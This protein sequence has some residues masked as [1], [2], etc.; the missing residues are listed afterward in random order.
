MT[1]S[2]PDLPIDH[3]TPA[4]KVVLSYGLGEDST[5]I[6][7]RWIEDP[8]SR[9]FDLSD[10]VVITAMTGDE[11]DS[12]RAAVEE[13]VLPRMTAAGI[14]Y[15]QVGRGRRHVT[16][17]GD[18]V[19]ILDDSSSPSRLYIEGE[20]SLYRE[21]TEA[22]TVPQSGGA[23]LC[24]VH[25]KGDALDPVI[26][27]ITRG[28]SYRHVM[29]FEAGEQR[30][31]VKDAMFNTD[32][33]T[34]EY[35]LI[36][37]GWTRDDAIAYTRSVTG[38]SVGKSACTFCPFT[39]ANKQGRADVFARYAADPTVG[40]KTLLME[41]LSLALNPAQGL[42]GGRR[43]IDMLRDQKLDGVV[44]AFTAVLEDQEHA[45][46]DV[47]RIPRPRKTDPTKLGNAARS[48]RVRGR[49]TRQGMQGILDRLAADGKA[50]GLVRPV[51]GEDGILRVYQHERGPAFPAIER[52]FV[53]APALAAAKE[54][55]KFDQWWS[56]AVATIA[57]EPAAA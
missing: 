53:V 48:I 56:D 30:R 1:I 25:A 55:E 14:R 4:P 13:H 17:A 57:L 9:D 29:G 27:R 10:L 34:G 8:T 31:A 50:K 21:M 49:G 26:A 45:I 51:V 20:Y 32:L 12:T 52:Y 3:S 43:L 42:V 24:S 39:F 35:P 37:W 22:G 46:Y 44:D 19:T 38:T 33:R 54:H 11:W 5:A 15:I 47:R 7:L 16:T 23:R 2:C 28:Q 40:A 18:G 36:D 41:H 6:L